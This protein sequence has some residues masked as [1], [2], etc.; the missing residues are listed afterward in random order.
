M[1]ESFGISCLDRFEARRRFSSIYLKTFDKFR[2]RGHKIMAKNLFFLEIAQYTCNTTNL[3]QNLPPPP[4][5]K[6]KQ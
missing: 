4:Q 2:D 6:K 5:Q 3:C 1:I